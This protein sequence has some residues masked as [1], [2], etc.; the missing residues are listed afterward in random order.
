M[1]FYKNVATVFQAW[2]IIAQ[3]LIISQRMNTARIRMTQRW[4]FHVSSEIH[5]SESLSSLHHKSANVHEH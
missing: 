2:I 3:K 4:P 5:L 1:F